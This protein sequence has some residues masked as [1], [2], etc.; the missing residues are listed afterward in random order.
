MVSAM[1]PRCGL[2]AVPVYL[3]TRPRCAGC[4]AELSVS[5]QRAL[6]A[7]GKRARLGGAVTRGIGWTVLASGLFVA[8]TLGLFFKWLWPAGILGY[9][10][11]GGVTLV[12]VLLAFALLR[13][14]KNLVTAG[15]NAE[16]EVKEKAIYALAARQHGRLTVRD[17]SRALRVTEREAD[18]LLTSLAVER[19]DVVAMD[20]DDE[21]VVSFRVA[22]RGSVVARGSTPARRAAAAAVP[23]SAASA[24][25]SASASASASTEEQEEEEDLAER[26]AHD[27]QQQHEH[28]ADDREHRRRA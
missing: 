21:G 1:C 9:L 7:P 20:V 3:G 17:V 26:R 5:S 8:L 23:A 12:T 22:R 10:V 2:S 16:R 27:E 15:T 24:P 6:V 11:G 25:A 18:E 13:G 19:S 14:G 4:G 28:D